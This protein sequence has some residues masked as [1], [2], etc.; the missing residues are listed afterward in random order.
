[1][2]R[3]TQRP[4]Q[5]RKSVGYWTSQTASASFRRGDA[6]CAPS[7]AMETNLQRSAFDYGA[8]TMRGMHA[9]LMLA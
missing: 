8:P 5:R 6:L 7:S 3:P 9:I 2:L 4:M 1:M